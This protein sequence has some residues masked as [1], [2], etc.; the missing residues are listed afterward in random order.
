[1][2]SAIGLRRPD[3]QGAPEKSPYRIWVS[4]DPFSNMG[5]CPTLPGTG[6]VLCV[7]APPGVFLPVVKTK[8]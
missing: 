1:M 5:S 3:D 8:V 2:T 4:T 7:P 6:S